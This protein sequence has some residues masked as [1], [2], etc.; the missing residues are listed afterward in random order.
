MSD[1]RISHPEAIQTVYP[2]NS[3]GQPNALI[4]AARQAVVD[5]YN[6]RHEAGTIVLTPE[7]LP[8]PEVIGLDEVYVVW[9]A[10]V[11]QN[12]KALV[13]TDVSDGRYYE[14]TFNGDQNVIYID[15]Y[16]KLSNTEVTLRH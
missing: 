4:D 6:R 10:K 7:E 3:H 1:P 12:W 9:F 14:V 16:G 15:T 8:T 11:L 5:E 2:T 13:S